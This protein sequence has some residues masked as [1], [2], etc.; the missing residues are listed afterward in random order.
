M[1]DLKGQADGAKALHLVL[2]PYLMRKTNW[3]K[4]TWISG[5]QGN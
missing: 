1:W 3:K 5:P 2:D 4:E